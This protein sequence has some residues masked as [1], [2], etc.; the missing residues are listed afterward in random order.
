[1]GAVANNRRS[2]VPHTRRAINMVRVAGMIESGKQRSTLTTA[3][4]I[5]L[6][7]LLRTSSKDTVSKSSEAHGRIVVRTCSIV[8][9]HF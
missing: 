3:L 7:L 6:N 4:M 5:S 1:M 2:H 8:E 9:I